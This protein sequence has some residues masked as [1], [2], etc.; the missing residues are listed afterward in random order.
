MSTK[1]FILA[2]GSPQRLAL[3][4]NIGY[5]PK[6]I[7]AANIDETPLPKEMPLSYIRR[8]A[9]AKAEAVSALLPNENILS[10]D[11]IIVVG[12]KIIQKSFISA[13]LQ[14]IKILP[15]AMKISPIFIMRLLSFI[16]VFASMRFLALCFTLK[17]ALEGRAK[18][19]LKMHQEH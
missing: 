17:D 14:S 2:S 12:Q 15:L 19:I 9:R 1:D 13:L 7:H 8:I 5:E 4:K 6:E 3:L 16:P 10:A 18:G 11:T